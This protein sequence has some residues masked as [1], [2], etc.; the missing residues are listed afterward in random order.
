MKI[1]KI[2]L[3]EKDRTK[4]VFDI[5]EIT[6]DDISEPSHNFQE[7]VKANKYELL[8]NDEYKN[9]MIFRFCK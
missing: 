5:V 1:E 6:S 7:F 4:E 3:D 8:L 2:I 9:K